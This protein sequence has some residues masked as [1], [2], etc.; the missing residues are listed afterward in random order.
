MS[1]TDDSHAKKTTVTATLQDYLKLPAGENTT[2]CY[3]AETQVKGLLDPHGNSTL[4][5]GVL[6]EALEIDLAFTCELEKEVRC[7]PAGSSGTGTNVTAVQ[8]L[9]EGL[10]EG[11]EQCSSRKFCSC[12]KFSVVAKVMM[13]GDATQYQ[14]TCRRELDSCA[15]AITVAEHKLFHDLGLDSMYNPAK[16]ACRN[17]CSIF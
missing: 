13:D 15:L 17:P 14:R 8:A 2:E 16:D 11:S 6:V 1:I 7:S 12:A 10:A 5:H 4:T 3:S 9:G